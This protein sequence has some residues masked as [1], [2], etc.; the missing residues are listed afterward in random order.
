MEIKSER[1]V[2]ESVR[3]ERVSDL[4]QCEGEMVSERVRVCLLCV[5]EGE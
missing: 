1:T 2:S 3:V 4:D 5:R